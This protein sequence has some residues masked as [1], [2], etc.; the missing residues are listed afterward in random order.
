MIAAE[1]LRF[2][3]RRSL[4]VIVFAIPLLVAFFFAA[5]FL[6]LKDIPAFDA[7]AYRQ[8]LLD[9]GCCIGMEPNDQ[10][11]FLNDMVGNQQQQY[12]QQDT[13]IRNSRAVFAFPQSIV[14]ALGNGP[15]LL[16]ALIL[17]TATTLGDEFAWGTIR[18]ALLASSRR[19]AFLGVRLGGLALTSLTVIV[20]MILVGTVMPFLLGVAGSRLP[21]P[22]PAVD[23]AALGVLALGLFF[24]SLM[25]IGFAAF[26]TLMLRSGALTLVGGL[27]YLAI[28]AAILTLLTR[29]EA[30]QEKGALAWVLDAFPLH[31]MTTLFR[32]A[33]EAAS[34][35]RTF[36]GPITDRSIDATFVP[37]VALAV[38]AAIFVSL[39]MVRFQR[40]DIVE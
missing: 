6:S 34:G 40:M 35:L 29:F 16:L 7:A 32:V 11:Q 39:A 38:W 37:L 14:T 13:F 8:E 10:E 18:T 23:V 26:V 36:A 15:I 4:Q 21:E 22:M 12:D 5:G 27:V 25:A 19:R 28:E 9:Q 24:A 3:K 1:L 20:L 2:R 33:G 31:G 30:F 17:L